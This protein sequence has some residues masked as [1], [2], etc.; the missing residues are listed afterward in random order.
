ML[1]GNLVTTIGGAV[2]YEGSL[3]LVERIAG[4]RTADQVAEALY[5]F[6]WREKKAPATTGAR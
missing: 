6:R 5:Y 4:P 1:D 3:A 2:S